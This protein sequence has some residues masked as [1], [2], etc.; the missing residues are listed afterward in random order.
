MFPLSNKIHSSKADW[1]SKYA[2]HVEC[3]S[4]QNL[5]NPVH[6]INRI[7]YFILLA[8][9]SSRASHI[10]IWKVKE[11]YPL[12]PFCCVLFIR[13]DLW[14]YSD[15]T[16]RPNDKIR[17]C[18]QRINSHE[19]QRLFFSFECSYNSWHREFKHLL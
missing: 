8:F 10:N 6:F 2:I 15:L 5:T 4:Y 18:F 19:F 14:I 12:T 17:F 7:S 1:K 11:Y 16:I 13:F 3:R 9:C